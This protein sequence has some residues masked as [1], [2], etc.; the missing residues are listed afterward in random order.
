MLVHGKAFGLSALKHHHKATYATNFSTENLHFS[1]GVGVLWLLMCGH[2]QLLS[3]T[4][5]LNSPHILT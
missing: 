1:I 4:A 5:A 3:G 2:E